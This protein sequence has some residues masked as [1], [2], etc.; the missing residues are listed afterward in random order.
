M[1]IKQLRKGNLF[2]L[3]NIITVMMVTITNPRAKLRNASSSGKMSR[4]AGNILKVKE[5]SEG[6]LLKCKSI[7]ELNRVFEINVEFRILARKSIK[8]SSR[9]HHFA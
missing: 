5:E 1:I 4:K 8:L 3:D 2:Y 7:L 6:N 9:T